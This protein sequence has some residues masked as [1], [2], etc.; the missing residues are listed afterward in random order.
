MGIP[1]LLILRYNK[2]VVYCC[3]QLLTVVSSL[4]QGSASEPEADRCRL[5]IG[6]VRTLLRVEVQGGLRRGGM[7]PTLAPR[8]PAT[9]ENVDES[10]P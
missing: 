7:T 5:T 9:T 2:V 3:P 6:L 10:R 1:I 8:M 4:P